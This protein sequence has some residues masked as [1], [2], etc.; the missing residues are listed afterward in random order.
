MSPTANEHSNEWIL[1]YYTGK[2]QLVITVDLPP[3]V[4]IFRARPQIRGVV[5][6][7]IFSVESGIA[8]P[9]DFN[10]L[11]ERTVIE[12]TAE[13]IRKAQARKNKI[14]VAEQQDDIEAGRSH[15]QF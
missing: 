9:E 4:F 10:D 11:E 14:V 2:E 5:S 1:I 8:L 13:K 3:N 6:A 7:I 12:E 15:K